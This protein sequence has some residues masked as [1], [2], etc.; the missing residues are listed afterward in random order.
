MVD[1]IFEFAR[2]GG[3]PEPGARADL[4]EVVEQVVDEVRQAEAPEPPEIVVE[5]F[6]PREVA[7]ARGVVASVLSNLTRNA[8]KFM[9]DSAHRRITVRVRDDGAMVRVEVEDTGPG[10]PLGLERIIFEPYARAEGVTQPGLG[11][12]LATVKR[13]CEAYGGAVGVRSSASRGATFWVTFPRAEASAH[14]SPESGA[15]PRHAS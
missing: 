6:A 14:A 13:L 10:V 8:A 5:P 11:L 12:G 1:G 4:E 7:C 15:I 9:R 2:S 3:R